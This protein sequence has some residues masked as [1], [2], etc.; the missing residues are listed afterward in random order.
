MSIDP[1]LTIV[2]YPE[3]QESQGPHKYHLPGVPPQGSEE[4]LLQEEAFL[5]AYPGPSPAPK[6]E[7]THFRV[8]VVALKSYRY[9]LE[10]SGYPR[11]FL[12][13]GMK[14]R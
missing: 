8:V 3:R 2:V 13:V 9:V 14:G 5:S 6:P 10:V 11:G 7:I 12:M 4:Q 1:S